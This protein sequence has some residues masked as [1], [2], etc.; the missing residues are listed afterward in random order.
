MKEITNNDLSCVH[1]GE[2]VQG[3]PTPDMLCLDV[4]LLVNA[5]RAEPGFDI[6]SAV[7]AL[8]KYCP[9]DFGDQNTAHEYAT[10]GG[11]P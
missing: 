3:W 2:F 4:K 5:G 7:H 8:M 11:I 9:T 1:G 6:S 10:T